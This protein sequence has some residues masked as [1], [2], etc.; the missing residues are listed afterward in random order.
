MVQDILIGI[1]FLA[2]LGFLGNLLIRS[3][4][5]KDGC[6]TGC[7]QCSVADFEK[8]KASTKETTPTP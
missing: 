7:G 3:F 2:A 5:K 4:L 1:V 6:V 8:L